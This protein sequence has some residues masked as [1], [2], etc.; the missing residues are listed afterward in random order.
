MIVRILGEGQW[1]VSDDRLPALNEL[2]SAVEAAV[3]QGDRETFSQSLD[4]LLNAVRAAGSGG[5][6][7]VATW[8][9]RRA[10]A[11]RRSGAC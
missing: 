7:L 4:A 2:D 6:G 11:C 10:D 3:E 8:R 9:P 5:R 1:N